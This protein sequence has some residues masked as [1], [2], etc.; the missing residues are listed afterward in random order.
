MKKLFNI[1]GYYYQVKDYNF[2]KYLNIKRKGTDVKIPDLMVVMMNPGSSQ[3]LNKQDNQRKETPAKP[4]NTQTQIMKIMQVGNFNYARVLNLSDVREPKSELLYPMLKKMEAQNINHSIF[5]E[6]R[7][8]DFNKLWIKN[9]SVIFGWGVNYRL[10]YLALKALSAC[11]ITNPIGLL[12]PN[13]NW[14]YYHPLP[15]NTNTQKDWVSGISKQL[16]K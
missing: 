12:K 15:P 11:D 14:A 3:P 4:D 16:K 5:A 13:T 9:T 6:E 8:D 2:R 10:R 7:K 1:T